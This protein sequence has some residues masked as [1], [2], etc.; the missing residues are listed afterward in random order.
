MQPKSNGDLMHLKNTFS[1]LIG[2]NETTLSDEGL[3]PNYFLGLTI[4]R[5]KSC[6][7][8]HLLREIQSMVFHKLPCNET[9]G[10]KS[11]LAPQ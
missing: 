8:S 7:D 4:S 6:K 9:W 1:Y 5:K 11:E 3:K 10:I 2:G